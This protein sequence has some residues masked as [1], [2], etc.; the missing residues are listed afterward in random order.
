MILSIISEFILLQYLT[1]ALDFFFNPSSD[2][3][4]L[5]DKMPFWVGPYT[6]VSHPSWYCIWNK[7]HEFTY[8]NYLI[9]KTLSLLQ[10]L[11]C[12][13]PWNVLFWVKSF[14][15]IPLICLLRLRSTIFTVVVMI[16]WI[17][18]YKVSG[19]VSDIYVTGNSWRKRK[20]NDYT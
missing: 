1:S 14:F 8:I 4:S 17:N 5:L 3:D 9:C 11:T 10:H 2:C 12:T 20:K 7:R 18:I 13:V 15:S 19:I 16:I 6:P